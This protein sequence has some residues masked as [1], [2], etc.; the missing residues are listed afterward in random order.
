METGLLLAFPFKT[1]CADRSRPRRAGRGG[2]LRGAQV[3]SCP[4]RFSFFGFKPGQ[5]P[6]RTADAAAPRNAACRCA[7]PRFS[8]PGNAD[9]L[10]GTLD[11]RVT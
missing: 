11:S 2:T 4:G 10:P 6:S 3:S 1:K 8:S 5:A 7:G 9:T